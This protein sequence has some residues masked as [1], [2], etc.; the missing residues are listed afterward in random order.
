VST[1]GAGSR[2]CGRGWQ[3]PISNY[4]RVPKNHDAGRDKAPLALHIIE[5]CKKYG[6]VD[7]VF[8]L[9]HE[10]GKQVVNFLRDGSQYGVDIKYSFSGEPLGTAGELWLAFSKKLIKPPTI[11][12]Y[13]DTLC[14]TNLDCLM[15][16]HMDTQADVSVVVNDEIRIP[17]GYVEDAGGNIITIKEKPKISELCGDRAHGFNVGG[18]LPI[19]YVHDIDFYAT[20]CRPHT[21][22]VTD[23]LPA[24]MQNG[25]RLVAHHDKNMFIDIGNFQNWKKAKK[26]EGRNGAN[27]I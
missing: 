6:I 27:N 8:C 23:V 17:V 18:I 7:F 16:K 24:M 19:F 14:T 13:G 25:Y 10:K 22:V 1:N 15:K 5:H 21:D 4:G 2:R 9:N 11:I 20:H 12:Y 26:W 3:S